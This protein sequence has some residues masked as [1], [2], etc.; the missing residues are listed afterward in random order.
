MAFECLKGTESLKICS[1]G[2]AKNRDNLTLASEER[3]PSYNLD[4]K[5]GI[6]NSK[7]KE[8]LIV[9]EVLPDCRSITELPPVLISEILNCLEP[10]ELGIVSCASTL[11]YRLASEHH[12]WKEFYCERWGQPTCQA[13]FG[14]EHSGEKS[15]KELFVER[16]FRSKTFM[17][18]YTIDMLYGH[19]EDVRTVFVLSSKKLVLTSGYDQIVRMWDL[20]EGLSIAS[21]RPLGCTI[22]AVAAD[23]RL[24]VAGGT[25]GF[26]HGWRANDENPHLFDLGAPQN[27]N[28]EFRVWEHD[29]PITCLALDFNRMYSGSWDTSIRVWNRSSLECLKVLIHNDWVWS[30]GPHDATLVSTAG[31]DLYVWDINSGSKLAIVKNAHSGYTYSLARS[32]TG[33]LLFTGGEDGAIHM[34]E[35]FGNSRCHVRRVATWIPHSSAVNSLAFEFPWLVSASSDGK[36]SLIDVRKLLRTNRNSTLSN[37]S[38]ADNLVDNVEPPQ[39]ML[40]GFGSNL[41]A[42]DVGSNRIV[43]AGEEGVVR[44]WNFSQA[45]EIEQRVQA[46]RG[47]RLENRVRRR[48]HQ[49]E[50]NGKGRRGDQCSFAAKKNQIDGDRNSWHNRRRMTWKVKA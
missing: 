43:C 31:S 34:F 25:D 30:L 3:K 24:L 32:H 4:A 44:I 17:G 22:R 2:P 18:R 5:G 28:M 35:I 42:V 45:L 39:R 27:Q 12:V 7:R 23:S 48:K 10:K 50:M 40:H 38:K 11:L 21:S 8:L 19:T 29:G 37:S 20:E 36:L 46:L 15:W 14:A 49:L 41:F 16:E 6:V 47:L 1:I 13:P 26:I 33:K 9:N